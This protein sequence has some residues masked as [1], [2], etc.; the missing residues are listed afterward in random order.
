M[1]QEGAEPAA[2]WRHLPRTLVRH[3]TPDA[4]HRIIFIDFVVSGWR[5]VAVPVGWSGEVSDDVDVTTTSR[6]GR[7]SVPFGARFAVL[8]GF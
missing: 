4:C 7:A 2:R 1:E 3:A 8:I 5:L 6:T